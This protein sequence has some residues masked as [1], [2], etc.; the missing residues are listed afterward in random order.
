M[1]SRILSILFPPQLPGKIRD[2]EER[3]ERHIDEQGWAGNVQ[4]HYRDAIQRHWAEGAPD[5]RFRLNAADFHMP[6]TKAQQLL[7]DEEINLITHG[8]ACM[9]YDR[10]EN[11]AENS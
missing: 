7:V 9:V 5:H 10:W 11:D 1:L 4:K 2:W 3:V 8:Y 6:L